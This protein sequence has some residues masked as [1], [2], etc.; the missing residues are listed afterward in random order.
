MTSPAGGSFTLDFDAT[1]F[2]RKEI[3]NGAPNDGFGT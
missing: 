2:T 3:G 1:D